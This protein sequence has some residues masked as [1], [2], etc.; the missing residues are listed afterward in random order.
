MTYFKC[1]LCGCKTEREHGRQLYCDACRDRK[2]K[3]LSLDV[4]M[5][6]CREC[7]GMIVHKPNRL[8]CETCAR[9]RK[10]TNEREYKKTY[11]HE[12]TQKPRAEKKPYSR[13]RRTGELFDL[14]GKSIEEVSVE[15]RALNMTYGRY[16]AA[17]MSGAIERE[18]A[19]LGIDRHAASEA[20]KKEKRRCAAE[21]KRRLE[22]SLG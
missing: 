15:A 13:P 12:N 5:D 2:K 22:Q 18:L 11:P 16:S 8:Y 9:I 19:A 6:R 21:K 3:K 4:G 20:I 1:K 14:T 10:K 7:G 17:C